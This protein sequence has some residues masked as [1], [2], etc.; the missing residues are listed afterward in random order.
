[1][2]QTNGLAIS[3]LTLGTVQLGLP[4]G[5]GNKTGMPTQEESAE[6]LQAALDGG[7]NCL[8]TAGAYGK[9]EQVL[10]RYFQ[11]KPKPL[12]VTKVVLKAG[13]DEP[14]GTQFFRSIEQSRT[15]LGYKALPVLMLHQPDILKQHGD[16]VTALFE[17]AKAKGLIERAGLSLGSN[18]DEQYMDIRRY[19]QL[20]LFEAI[21][22]AFN[23]L[24]HR[25]INH[26]W[27]AELRGWGKTIFV[28]SVFL[29]GLL[30]MQDG[31][32]PP[33][34]AG[35]KEPLRRFRELAARYGLTPAQAAV[36]FVRDL[37]EVDSLVMGAETAEQVRDN[38]RLIDGPAMPEALRNEI[39]QA[40][41]GLPESIIDPVKWPVKFN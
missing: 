34:L 35:A 20:P 15:E 7:V 13:G 24:D 11:G 27:L 38:V 36:S 22:V 30:V 8:D 39:M 37:P 29:Q 3:K 19:T 5:I 18:V 31:D 12:I 6:I 1:M 28:R 32:V 40:L 25:L 9:S 21:Q 2:K 26:G 17:Q 16:E 33:H 41:S 14:L 23:A 4:Y 10:G